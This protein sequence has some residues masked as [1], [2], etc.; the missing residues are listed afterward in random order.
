MK[1]K[2]VECATPGHTQ[3]P[4]T[5]TPPL[6]VTL[7]GKYAIPGKN[8]QGAA[9]PYIIHAKAEYKGKTKAKSAHEYKWYKDVSDEDLLGRERKIGAAYLQGLG[10]D[11]RDNI[12]YP[13]D[14]YLH[15]PLGF[16]ISVTKNGSTTRECMLDWTV[17]FIKNLNDGSNGE[18]KKGKGGEPVIL[19]LDGHISR[20][21]M[22]A[23]V[24][25]LEN[26][27]LPFFSPSHTSIMWGQMNDCGLNSSIQSYLEE[28]ASKE[29]MH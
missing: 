1:W 18:Q 9:S 21:N 23:I 17:H 13:A 24:L 2:I 29:R 14:G 12:Q 27:V 6:Y 5:Q 25:M 8:I 20:W 15:N 22:H 16:G 4:P 11:I 19:T 28:A 7:T 26:N 3:Q 10:Q